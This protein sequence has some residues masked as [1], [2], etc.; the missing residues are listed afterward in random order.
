[1]GKNKIRLNI[2]GC[3]CVLNSEESESYIHSVGDEVQNT[4]EDMIA[5]ND[6]I[7][8][9]M[10][11]IITA[12][13]YCDSARKAAAASDNLRSQ[14]KDYLEDSS[15]ARMDADESRREIERLKHEIQ[16]LRARLDSTKPADSTAAA[17]GKRP[18]IAP[19]APVQRPQTGNYSTVHTGSGEPDQDQFITFFEKKG[20]EA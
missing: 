5:N 9:V 14:I 16:T 1:M 12:L 13:N 2:C 17:D 7:S 8:V 4:I 15:H 6:R 3:E 10:A 19:G 20:D 18:P 11:A